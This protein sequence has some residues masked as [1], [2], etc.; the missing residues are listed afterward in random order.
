[1]RLRS[2]GKQAGGTRI[3][4]TI[5]ESLVPAAGGLPFVNEH[6]GYALVQTVLE[7]GGPPVDA[8]KTWPFAD[9]HTREGFDAF[10]RKNELRRLQLQQL[11]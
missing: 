10:A 9:F 2:R 11:P 6:G 3:A 8:G 5:S 7:A 4:N 1:M